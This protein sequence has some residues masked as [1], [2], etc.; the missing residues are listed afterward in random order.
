MRREF[1]K[2]V[3]ID[4][5][6]PD[7]AQSCQS[8]VTIKCR[9]IWC[10]GVVNAKL[11]VCLY[12]SPDRGAAILTSILEWAACEGTDPDGGAKSVRTAVLGV[13]Q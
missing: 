13:Y 6:R 12:K 11:T 10:A 2:Y 5:P 1:A 8:P 4:Q 9:E 3:Q 7:I